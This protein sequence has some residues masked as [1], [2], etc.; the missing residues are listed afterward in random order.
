MYIG[1]QKIL[2]ETALENGDIEVTLEA[3][4]EVI[5]GGG[6]KRDIALGL[7]KEE[8]IV[9]PKGILDKIKTEESQEETAL[10]N[11]WASKPIAEIVLALMNNAVPVSYFEHIFSSVIFTI[12]NAEKIK[13]R[14]VSGVH[15]LNR[16]VYQLKNELL[17]GA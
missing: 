6:G 9:Y 17:E 11:A 3:R 13:D 7:K 1:N 12:Q 15:E 10:R 5:L 14:R 2:Q 16:N 4:Q 8:I